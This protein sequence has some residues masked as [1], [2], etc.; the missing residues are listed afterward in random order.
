LAGARGVRVLERRTTSVTT[1]P[2]T[3]H[4][5]VTCAECGELFE[6]R[7]PTTRYLDIRDDGAAQQ[8]EQEPMLA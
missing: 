7:T 3:R 6:R 2:L 1:T 4:Q 5:P 8:T